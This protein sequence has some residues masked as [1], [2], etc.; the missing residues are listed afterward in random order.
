VRAHAEIALAWETPPGWARAALARPL[1]LLSDH[2]HCELGAAAAAQGL[3][4]RH[5]AH[6][7]VVAKLAALAQEELAH[8]RRVHCALRALGGELGPP[9][10]NAYVDGLRAAAREVDAADGRRLA[11]WLVA[12]LVER[13]SRERFERLAAVAP[14]PLRALWA[15]LAAAEAGHARL[16]LDLAAELQGA[17]RVERLL[18]EML[19][20]EAALLRGLA[21]GPRVHSGPPALCEQPVASWR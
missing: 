13:R 19:R 17:E 8:F 12:A 16:F 18:P 15:E 3:I 1:D 14:E 5:A 7:R 21:P 20:R 4:V 6:G 11:P 10:R 9:R 2:A